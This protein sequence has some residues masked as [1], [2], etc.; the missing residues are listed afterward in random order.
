VDQC[1]DAVT[2]VFEVGVE[3]GGGLLPQEFA[4]GHENGAI[5]VIAILDVVEQADA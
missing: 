5:P 3:V 2:K 4:H 1:G